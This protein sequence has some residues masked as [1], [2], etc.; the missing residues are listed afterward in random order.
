M[1]AP[2]LQVSGLKVA[3]GHIEAVK[4]IDLELH[5]GQITTLAHARPKKVKR[6]FRVRQ[7]GLRHVHLVKLRQVVQG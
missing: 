7:Y 1:S 6:L 3:Y 5:A 2:L 4:G